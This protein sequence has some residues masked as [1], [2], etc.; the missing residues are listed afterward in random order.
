MRLGMLA[1]A[2]AGRVC[3]GIPFFQNCDTTLRIIPS[4]LLNT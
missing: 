1:V 2:H 4:D 3:A